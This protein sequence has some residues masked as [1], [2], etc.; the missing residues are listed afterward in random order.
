MNHTINKERTKLTITIDAD[1]RE[2][3]RRMDR[4][5]P[6]SIQSDKA[7]HEFFE[8][9]IANSE[10]EWINPADTGDLT[11]APMLGILGESRRDDATPRGYQGPKIYC[12]TGMIQP[13]LERFGFADYQVVS[14]LETLRDRGE[15]IFSNQW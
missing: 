7:M 9:L 6:D 5:G 12:G 1:E 4:E 14:V 8:P 10:L 2:M 11:D 15:V 13:I 3:L